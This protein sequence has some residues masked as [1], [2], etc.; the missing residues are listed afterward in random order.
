MLGCGDA[1]LIAGGEYRWRISER[2]AA[3]ENSDLPEK[4]KALYREA[5]EF[6]YSPH[7]QLKPDMT[8]YWQSAAEFFRAAV[9]RTA[10]CSNAESLTGAIYLCCKKSGE[11]SLKNL[12]IYSVKTRSLPLT[13]I[14][15]YMTPAVAGI[16][17]EL[18]RQLDKLPVF[19][20]QKSKLY[21]FWL[22]FN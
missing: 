10:G 21:Q 13:G 20:V 9:L 7:R 17:P 16:L 6:K 18:Y 3:L 11:V 4:W 19:P 12:L 14:K 2:M 5:V 1:M 22:I 8:A 15:K